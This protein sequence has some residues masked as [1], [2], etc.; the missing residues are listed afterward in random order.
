MIDDILVW[1][2]SILG[3]LILKDSYIL[4]A[5]SFLPLNWANVIWYIDITPSKYLLVW[6]LIHN[7]VPTDDMLQLRGSFMA[8]MCSLCESN[9]KSTFHI[10][11]DYMFAKSCGAGSVHSFKPLSILLF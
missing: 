4:K 11:F 3:D 5:H 7:K 10:F 8:S 6:R 9:S 1:K 2:N